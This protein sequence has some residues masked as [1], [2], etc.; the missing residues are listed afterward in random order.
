MQI[1]CNLTSI[2]LEG[3]KSIMELSGDDQLYFYNIGAPEYFHTID[4]RSMVQI[5]LALG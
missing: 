4:I 2:F 3:L 1:T 5:D